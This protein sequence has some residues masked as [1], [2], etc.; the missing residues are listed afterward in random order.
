[1]SVFQHNSSKTG[2]MGLWGLALRSGVGA[3]GRWQINKIGRASLE[4]RLGAGCR[5]A[6][7][8]ACFDLD[9]YSF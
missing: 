4:A 2:P 6:R 3:G 7:R 5:G 8:A 1:M 9:A